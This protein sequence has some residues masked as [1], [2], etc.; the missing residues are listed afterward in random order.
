MVESTEICLAP[1]CQGILNRSWKLATIKCISMPLDGE[2][3]NIL[4]QCKE[5][6]NM[7]IIV[8]IYLNNRKKLKLYK[9]NV[10]M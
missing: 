3:F 8:A 4:K 10:L 1:P 5:T 9:E 7:L 2:H 6:N